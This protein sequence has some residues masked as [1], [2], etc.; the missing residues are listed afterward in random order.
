MSSSIQLRQNTNQHTIKNRISTGRE[1]TL[2]LSVRNTVVKIAKKYP[3]QRFKLIL[4][5]GANAF[6]YPRLPNLELV[7]DKL[8][9]EDLIRKFRE[10]YPELKENFSSEIEEGY[11]NPDGS[12]LLCFLANDWRVVM[13]SEHKHQGTNDQRELEGK[14]RQALGNA[15]ERLGKNLS[16][17]RSFMSDEDITPYVAFG[18]GCDFEKGKQSVR[19]RLFAMNDGGG[20]NQI[21]VNIWK[22]NNGRIFRPISMFFRKRMWSEPEM[23]EMLFEVANQSLS[24]YSQ[25]YVA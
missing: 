17:A 24:Y 14:P 3:N 16:Y 12:I 18:D 4:N 20:L 2:A 8:S 10:L 11:I 13:I 21:Y 19:G 7:F 9:N 25:K 22:A 6:S 1:K 5:S 15:I 23:S